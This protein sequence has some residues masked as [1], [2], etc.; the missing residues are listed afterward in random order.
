M[1][2]PLPRIAVLMSTYNGERFLAAQLDS[3][4]AQTGV[5]CEVFVRD[6]GSAD[7]TRTILA[8]YADRWPQLARPLTGPNLG[9]A[10]SFLELLGHVPTDFDHYAFCDQDDVWMPQ[11]LSRATGALAIMPP[12]E[13]ALYCSQVTCVDEALGPMGE[14]FADSD[15]RF[16]HMLFQNIAYGVTTV[17]NQAAREL[18]VSQRPRDGVIMHDWWCALAVAALGTLVYDPQSS[19]LYRQHTGNVI[20][21]RVNRLQEVLRQL[22]LVWRDPTGYWPI[23]AQAREFLHCFGDLLAANHRRLVGDLVASKASLWNRVRFGLTGGV[24]RAGRFGLISARLLILLGL[25]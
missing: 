10:F 4:A 14:P 1:P 11:K 24:V 5:V 2:E 25:Y 17:M 19:V 3:L 7:T 23:H 8:R 13:P 9:P 16:E 18:I 12:G 22:R 21:A 20:G 6:D 15:A